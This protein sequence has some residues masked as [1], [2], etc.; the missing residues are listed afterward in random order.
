MNSLLS[1]NQFVFQYYYSVIMV[2][3]AIFT[4]LYVNYPSEIKT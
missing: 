4:R 3:I 1:K 2:N